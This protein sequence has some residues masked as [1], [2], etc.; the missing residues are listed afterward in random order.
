MICRLH[1]IQ[2]VIGFFL[3]M[4]Q[5]AQT[6]ENKG[7]TVKYFKLNDVDNAQSFE[8]NILNVIQQYS[9][10]SFQYQLPDGHQ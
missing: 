7:F 8:A 5:F 3:S 10:Q 1:F 4:R 2:K 9:I 6:L